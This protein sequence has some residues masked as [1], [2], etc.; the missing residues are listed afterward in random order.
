MNI[1]TEG[2]PGATP[3]VT[4]VEK[5]GTIT[6]TFQLTAQQVE[7]APFGFVEDAQDW[8]RPFPAEGDYYQ[9]ILMEFKGN[10]KK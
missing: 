3:A 9:F 10:S 1:P 4:M 7:R 5:G 2:K 8:N 6:F